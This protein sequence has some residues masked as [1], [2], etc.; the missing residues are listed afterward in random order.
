MNAFVSKFWR[1]FGFL[2]GLSAL[3]A[4]V[5]GC[6]SLDSEE[7][8][9]LSVSATPT[10]L[11]GDSAIA[12]TV[13]T[14]NNTPNVYRNLGCGGSPMAIEREHEIELCNGNDCRPVTRVGPPKFDTETLNGIIS[15]SDKKSLVDDQFLA[16]NI[17]YTVRVKFPSSD[18]WVRQPEGG[19]SFGSTN[20]CAD[21]DTDTDT[22]TGTGTDIG[23]EP[24]TH[25][26][27]DNG[28][29]SDTGTGS[30]TIVDTPSDSMDSETD[31]GELEILKL[32]A[33]CTLD[34]PRALAKCDKVGEADDSIG[35]SNP[36]CTV[37]GDLVPGTR[38]RFNNM[39]VWKYRSITI[40]ALS[41][42]GTGTIRARLDENGTTLALFNITESTA[43][44][45]FQAFT[46]PLDFIR[47]SKAAVDGIH[48]ITLWAEEE[49]DDSG[50]IQIDWVE[51][52]SA[53]VSEYDPETCENMND[54]LDNCWDCA[55]N[56]YCSD[57]KA[58]CDSNPYCVELYDCVIADCDDPEQGIWNTCYNQ[59]LKKNPNSTR[60][61]EDFSDLKDCIM[62]DV[63]TFGCRKNSCSDLRY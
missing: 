20:A 4:G 31:T 45:G 11:N 52:S 47:L 1:F 7:P 5:F 55:L 30:D 43:D 9:I 25:T 38:I 13:T 19:I 54:C 59:C 29:D 48:A 15:E 46:A 18:K 14:R 24:D 22:G 10:Q 41:I 23:T 62:C 53:L 2:L 33:E 58:A 8:Q 57:Y 34:D 27:S 21:Q 42:G 35:C 37:I 26:V 51:L 40:Y 17:C 12:I 50:R 39:L 56:G 44:G 36:S 60:A 16:D 6:R 3:G 49:D 63:C 61:Q 28:N 32:E